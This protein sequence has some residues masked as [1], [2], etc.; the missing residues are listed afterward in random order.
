M[1]ISDINRNLRLGKRVRKKDLLKR[2]SIRLNPLSSIIINGYFNENNSNTLKN[3]KTLDFDKLI[4]DL[5]EFVLGHDYDFK[6]RFLFNV[7]DLNGD[8]K[9]DKDEMYTLLC[10]ITDQNLERHKILDIV[11]D[12][13]RDTEYITYDEF[14]SIIENHNFNLKFD[15][16]C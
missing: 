8:N 13:F 12:F 15:L 6:I 2:E 16:R 9:I 14:K 4:N 7:Y 5:Y 3:R 1:I 10:L 11:D